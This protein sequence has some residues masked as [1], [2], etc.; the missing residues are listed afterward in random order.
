MKLQSCSHWTVKNPEALLFFAQRINEMLFDYTLD[1][2]KPPAL[3]AA[4]LCG[5]A[6]GVLD[7]IERE[8]IDENHLN[9]ILE[10]LA[11]SLKNDRVAKSLL[12]ADP[13]YYLLTGDEVSKYERRVRL[14]VLGKSLN[15][16]R[17]ASACQDAIIEAIEKG[18]K[19]DIDT[20][21]RNFICSLVNGG[22]SKQ[23]LFEKTQRFF[24]SDR[25]IESLGCLHEY[26]DE[27]EIRFHTFN[28]YFR[29]N[30]LIDFVRKSDKYFGVSVLDV[31][32]KELAEHTSAKGFICDLGERY[33]HVQ[34]IQAADQYSARAEAERR[35]DSL[36]DLYTFFAHKSKFAW[37][38]Q[39]LMTQCCTNEVFLVSGTM[40]PM[41][42]GQNLPPQYAA[43]K[44]NNFMGTFG[45]RR[46]SLQKFKQVMDLHDAALASDIPASQILNIW[47]ALETIVPA[48]GGGG[49]TISRIVASLMP[50][51]LT[52]YIFRLVK[53]LMKDMLQ[54]DRHK[55]KSI[56]GRV[57]GKGNMEFKV[58]R[59]IA[60]NECDPLRK[61]LYAQLDD[62]PLLRY[63]VYSM[64]EKFGSPLSVMSMLEEHKRKVSW[65]IRRIYRVRNMVV[66]SGDS[67]NFIE[68]LI[69]N[70]HD[71]FDIMMS[72]IISYSCGHYDVS[73]LEQA[74]ELAA[75]RY[76]GF[77]RF[78]KQLGKDP[79][80]ADN[81]DS[82]REVW[83]E[84][85]AS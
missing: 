7:D 53:N 68:T 8:I 31:L 3:N 47:I 23:S 10:E 29:V 16:A 64:A 81:V 63:R 55:A 24:F 14:E 85:R 65:Q 17:Y 28:V 66:H 43:Q 36:N 54:W 51:L 21:A 4:S 35:L 46:G 6:L 67:P 60:L 82:L 11:W 44:L 13:E 79:F 32:P 83:M 38:P 33:V 15:L 70:G 49:N 26:F 5:E 40:S 80:K 69:E 37:R 72:G 22:V 71:Y 77:E 58:L 39:A 62:F 56:L 18:K 27:L 57:E 45:L 48:K 20:I 52:N 59:L 25:K 73:S 50:F 42:K 2:Y 61:E 9:H 74:F 76:Q 12:D 34:E 41:R 1:S 78:L 84:L 30:R 19:K 75:I